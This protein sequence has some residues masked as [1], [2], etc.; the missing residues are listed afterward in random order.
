MLANGGEG[1]AS[2]ASLKEHAP[3]R[4]VGQLWK[5]LRSGA[6]KISRLDRGGHT[7]TS[8][9]HTARCSLRFHMATGSVEGAG[10]A[11][12]GQDIMGHLDRTRLQLRHA[13]GVRRARLDAGVRPVRD[14]RLRY[15][16]AC[17]AIDDID[18][19]RPAAGLRRTAW[20]SA[21]T[22]LV[23][24]RCS[25][26]GTCSAS[27]APLPGRIRIRSPRSEIHRPPNE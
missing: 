19:R 9:T 4:P 23:Q 5:V 22:G 11:D 7:H 1:C 10:M 24:D 14:G 20:S 27:R 18:P 2:S 12:A 6:R 16:L 21:V 3:G 26:Q 25:I 8:G 13:L 15:L 17:R